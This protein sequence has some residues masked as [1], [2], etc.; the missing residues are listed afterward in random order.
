MIVPRFF[1]NEEYS[2]QPS[3]V[4]A[5]AHHIKQVLR[6]KLGEQ[7]S[8]VTEDGKLLLC[9]IASFVEQRVQLS[10]VRV[11]QESIQVPKVILAQGIIKGEKMDLVVQ[12]AVELGATDI[13]PLKLHRCV[14]EYHGDKADKKCDRWQ[15]IAIEAAKQSEQ[16]V[17]PTVH[18]VCTLTEMLQNCTAN[19]KIIAYELEKELSLKGALQK[20]DLNEDTIFI[21]GPEGGLDSAEV[22]NAVQNGFV[23]VSLGGRILRTETAPLMLLSCLQY[24]KE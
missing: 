22:Q 8:V 1:I 6:M 15:K 5:D 19:N 4:G 13:I 10:V 12:K 2:E 7:L 11:L 16:L 14:A 23:A 21:V 3:I 9:T 24:E 17:L 20:M 18:R